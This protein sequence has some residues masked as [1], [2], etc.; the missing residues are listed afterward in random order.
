[1][2]ADDIIDVNNFP[3]IEIPYDDIVEK[4]SY[5]MEKNHRKFGSTEKNL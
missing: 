1:M 3:N 2:T 4:E 5:E